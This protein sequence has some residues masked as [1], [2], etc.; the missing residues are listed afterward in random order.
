MTNGGA[1]QDQTTFLASDVISRISWRF[2]RRF[3]TEKK[4]NKHNAERQRT[5]PDAHNK[6][7]F[8]TRGRLFFFLFFVVTTGLDLVPD[9]SIKRYLHAHVAI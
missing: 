4:V 2:V 3:E 8:S 7:A 6:E 5:T 9:I 1:N